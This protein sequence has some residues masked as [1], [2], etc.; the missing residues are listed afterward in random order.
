MAC[1]PSGLSRS[2]SFLSS[3]ETQL[4]THIAYTCIYT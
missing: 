4:S 3:L 1:T 2:E